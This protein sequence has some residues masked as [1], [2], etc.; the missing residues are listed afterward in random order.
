MVCGLSHQCK[1]YTSGLACFESMLSQPEWPT[2]LELSRNS[3]LRLFL[4]LYR[5]IGISFSHTANS[6]LQLKTHPSSFS[7]PTG[8]AYISTITIAA[9]MLWRSRKTHD[10]TIFLH[11]KLVFLIYNELLRLFHNLDD[12]SSRLIFASSLV[13]LAA[14]DPA[15]RWGL[16]PASSSSPPYSS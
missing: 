14:P 16:K 1:L 9:F 12:H 11:L 5:S 10:V 7:D 15:K 8:H 4:S 3:L 6:D 2:S 13:C